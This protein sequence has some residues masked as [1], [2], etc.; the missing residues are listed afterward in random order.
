MMNRYGLTLII[1]LFTMILLTT[2]LVVMGYTINNTFIMQL[3]NNI[4]QGLSKCGINPSTIYIVS[5]ATTITNNAVV[6]KMASTAGNYTVELSI[7]AANNQLPIDEINITVTRDNV[8]LCNLTI[9][10]SSASGLYNY[11]IEKK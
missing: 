2:N 10:V 9:P 3:N 5:S 7:M 1:V 6:V 8:V 4:T 11:T